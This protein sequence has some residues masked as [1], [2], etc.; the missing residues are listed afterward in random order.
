MAGVERALGCFKLIKVTRINGVFNLGKVQLFQNLFTIETLD[1][2]RENK[3]DKTQIILLLHGD[4]ET[5]HGIQQIDK[6][7]KT[8]HYEF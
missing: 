5:S 2:P 1:H 4:L 3:Y 8:S 6:H 7:I